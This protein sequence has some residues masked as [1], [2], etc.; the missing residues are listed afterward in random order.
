ML[1]FKIGPGIVEAIQAFYPGGLLQFE[2]DGGRVGLIP[3]HKPEYIVLHP[4]LPEDL[5]EALLGCQK[6]VGCIVTMASVPNF[7]DL[8]PQEVL[9][10]LMERVDTSFFEC[11]VCAPMSI[12]LGDAITVVSVLGL[13]AA[14]IAKGLESLLKET[15]GLLRGCVITPR[16]V[17]RIDNPVPVLAKTEASRGRINDETLTDLKITLAGDKDV[18]D[19]IK[20]L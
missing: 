10:D 13:G 2:M 16:K 11:G 7:K 3:T 8:E 5:K 9:K 18:S 14:K 19:I 12:L 4:D 1:D 17:L 6:R 20:E 15:P